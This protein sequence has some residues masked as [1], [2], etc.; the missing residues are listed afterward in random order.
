MIEK[1]SHRV[2]IIG[3]ADGPT[4]VFIAGKTITANAHTLEE[5]IQ[6]LQDNYGAVEVSKELRSY[7]EQYKSIKE[8]LILQHKPKRYSVLL[9]VLS[10]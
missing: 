8:S 1:S 7:Q 5:V 9:A 4:S 6:Y 2:S 10:T 3:G